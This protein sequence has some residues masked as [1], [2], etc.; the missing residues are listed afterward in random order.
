MNPLATL[1]NI[2]HE[3]G[4]DKIVGARDKQEKTVEEQV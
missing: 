4:T 1:T 2:Q 3:K